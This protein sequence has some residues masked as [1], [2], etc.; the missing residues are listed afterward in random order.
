MYFVVK[1][2]IGMQIPWNKTLMHIKVEIFSKDIRE[3][4]DFDR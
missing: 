3:F 2:V 4:Q 1:D